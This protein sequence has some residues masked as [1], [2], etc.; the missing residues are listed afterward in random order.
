MFDR[1]IGALASS[2]QINDSRYLKQLFPDSTYLLSVASKSLDRGMGYL[3]KYPYANNGSEMGSNLG[4]LET[5]SCFGSV[6]GIELI[7]SQDAGFIRV[8]GSIFDGVTQKV[9]EK[10]AIVDS[11]G[12]IIGFALSGGS[13]ADARKAYGDGARYAKFVGYA[14]SSA[15]GKE[16]R[17]IPDSKSCI[18]KTTVPKIVFE[19]FTDVSEH[20]PNIS[21]SS[22]N[23]VTGFNGRSVDVPVGSMMGMNVYSSFITSDADRGLLRIKVKNGDRLMYRTGPVSN[24]QWI[25]TPIADA[26]LPFSPDWSILKFIGF[27]DDE[28][29]EVE[30]EDAGDGWGEWSAIALRSP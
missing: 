24:R 16:I 8:M 6:D 5:H 26:V 9:P 25:R 14:K 20:Y 10:L 4:T 12:N 3:T 30:L 27:P 23:L 2:L 22:L 29:H 7:S 28:L 17:L 18:L 11:V 13:S 21:A 19:H 15:A 1:K